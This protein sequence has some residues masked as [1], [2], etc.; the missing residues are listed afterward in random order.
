[1]L[2]I[3]NV[4]KWFLL[5]LIFQLPSLLVF[6]KERNSS[7][8]PTPGLAKQ[9]CPNCDTDG[10]FYQP[11]QFFCPPSAEFCQSEKKFGMYLDVYGLVWQSKEGSLEFAAKNKYYTDAIDTNR[12]TNQITFITPDFGWKPGFKLEA[13]YYLPLDDWD[14]KTNWTHYD[15]GFSNNKKHVNVELIPGNNGVI[16]VQFVYYLNN[17]TTAPRF[18]HATGDLDIHFNSFDLDTGRNFWIGKKFSFRPYGG[19]KCGWIDQN[20]KIYYED[21]DAIISSAESNTYV[22]SSISKFNNNSLGIGPKIGF[23]AKCHFKKYFQL[24]ANGSFAILPTKFDLKKDQNDAMRTVTIEPAA[25]TN[26]YYR[27][28]LK[29][30]VYMYNPNIGLQLGFGYGDCFFSRYFLGL[31]MSYEMQYWWGQNQT[32]RFISRKNFALTTPSRGDLMLH[33]LSAYLKFEF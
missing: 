18:T 2:S 3:K 33:G 9:S 16:P 31:F 22:D 23:E 8:S 19:L 20:Y 4:N 7:N 10:N 26:T 15:G 6:S 28:I 11:S 13:G 21:S 12:I 17:S 5:I 32:R 27:F 1:M 30:K 14:I 24:L 29:E 25:T